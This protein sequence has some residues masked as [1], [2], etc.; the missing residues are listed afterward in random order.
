MYP[1]YSYKSACFT[2]IAL[3]GMVIDIMLQYND[4]VVHQRFYPAIAQGHNHNF[5]TENDIINKKF[6]ENIILRDK[7]VV[8]N[9][10]KHK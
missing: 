4:S 2:V 1:L 10:F 6:F 7:F 9:P 5:H 3:K 8:L